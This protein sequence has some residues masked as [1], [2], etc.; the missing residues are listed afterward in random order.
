MSVI[1]KTD[2]GSFVY[3]VDAQNKAKLIPVQLGNSYQNKVEVL[4]GIGLG[5]RVIT[6]GY[7]E[8]NEGDLV[9][10]D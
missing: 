5:E 4:N 8:L 3:V 2:N 10:V 9:Q 7:E 6:V 1:Q